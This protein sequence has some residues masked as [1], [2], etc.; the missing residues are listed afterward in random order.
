MYD[1]QLTAFATR[2]HGNSDPTAD[3]EGST[4]VLTA[5]KLESESDN[6]DLTT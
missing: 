3:D 5:I 1:L 6:E 4:G 2:V